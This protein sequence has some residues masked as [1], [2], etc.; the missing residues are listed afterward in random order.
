V[1]NVLNVDSGQALSFTLNKFINKQIS[2]DSTSREW[3]SGNLPDCFLRDHWH[4]GLKLLK[5][6]ETLH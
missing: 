2:L 6:R 4:D 1:E 5:K 3:N